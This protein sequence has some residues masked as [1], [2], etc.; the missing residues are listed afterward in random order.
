MLMGRTVDISETGI[1]AMLRME[2]PLGE[3]VQ[4][5]FTLPLGQVEVAALVRQQHAFRY[6]FQFV[7]QGPVRELIARTCRDL[8]LEQFFDDLS[9]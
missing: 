4:L 6:G 8:S 2:V 5:E 7:E 1:A 9:H 3:V